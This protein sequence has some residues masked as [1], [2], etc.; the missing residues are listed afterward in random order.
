M[1][2]RVFVIVGATGTVGRRLVELLSASGVHVRAIARA[3]PPQAREP[4]EWVEADIRNFAAAIRA[5]KEATDVYIAPPEEGRDPLLNERTIVENVLHVAYRVGT[6]HVVMHTGLGTQRGASA[7]RLAD[8]KV[9]MERVLAGSGTP[10]TILRPGLF[11][12][13]LLTVQAELARGVLEWP[14]P[15]DVALPWVSAQDVAGAAAELLRRGP[16]NRSLDVHAGLVT[17]AE[18]AQTAGRVLG[19]PVECREEARLVERLH[20]DPAVATLWREYY[21]IAPSAL[22]PPGGQEMLATLAGFRYSALEDV[23]ARHL[24]RVAATPPG[25]DPGVPEPVPIVGP[26]A[27][28][29]LKPG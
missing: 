29:T 25:P 4:V 8:T 14:V 13:R 28:E 20:P 12:E 18:V 2:D 16:Q 27:T 3:R 26:A 5:L 21:E 11:L 23:L 6:R 22:W 1:G 7:L 24:P 19:H 10:Y 9:Q 15:A 17:G